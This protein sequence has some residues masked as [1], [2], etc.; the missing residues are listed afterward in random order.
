LQH[1]HES[2]I[3]MKNL[4]G[5]LEGN[6]E[7]IRQFLNDHKFPVVEHV[8]PVSFQKYLEEEEKPGGKTLVWFLF[9]KSNAADA[10]A[11]EKL[12]YK[13]A[14]K[15]EFAQTVAFLY[16][17]VGEDNDLIEGVLFNDE[18]SIL[19]TLQTPTAVVQAKHG[20]WILMEKA[21]NE[22]NF[23][24]WLRNVVSKKIVPKYISEPVVEF[25][26][27]NPENVQIIVGSQMEKM[28]FKN[29]LDIA[30]LVYASWCGHCTTMVKEFE[31]V[32]SLLKKIGMLGTDIKMLRMDGDQNETTIPILDYDA[33]PT[34]FYLKKGSPT[35]LVYIGKNE[36]KEVW[37]WM[38]KSASTQVQNTIEQKRRSGSD[39]K[40]LSV[41][42]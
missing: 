1:R 31:K 42:L 34:V 23:E 12:M 40:D 19:P 26:E 13:I 2:I 36:A 15:E 41:E 20:K 22:E 35:P 4:G 6:S 10:D 33:F 32:A 5:V 8:N 38:K 18:M 27:N 30:F 14:E 21:F 16:A 37:S 3:E 24:S 28:F 25:D 7:E 17:I 9:S 29:D 11:R 39:I